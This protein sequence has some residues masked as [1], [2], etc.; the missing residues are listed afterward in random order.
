MRVI[1]LVILCTFVLC[2]AAFGRSARAQ[3]TTGSVVGSIADS[4]GSVIPNATITLTN[5]A[6]GDKRT[7]IT[8]DSGD[9]Q[10]LSLPPGEYTLTVE[11]QGF[12]RYTHNPVEV[13]VELAT[14]E[15][16]D[17]AV[18]APPSRSP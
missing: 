15:N 12:R 7:V 8:A 18:G 10:F 1:K 3:S 17:M 6:T 11:A 16:V 13:Q 9:Y 2:F 4:T 14:R 5:N